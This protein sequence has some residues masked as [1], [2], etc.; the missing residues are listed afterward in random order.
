M[1][2]VILMVLVF[3]VPFLFAAP[4]TFEPEK[5]DI[6]EESYGV[7]PNYVRYGTT[8]MLGSPT[9]PGYAFSSWE[10]T[11]VIDTIDGSWREKDFSTYDVVYHVWVRL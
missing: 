1:K 8:V 10:L 11:S 4:R 5:Y 2:K 9:N 6:G 7:M 3:A